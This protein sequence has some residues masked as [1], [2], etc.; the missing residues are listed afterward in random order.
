MAD[1]A[2]LAGTA[3]HC[4]VRLPGVGF[5]CR[6]G[7]RPRGRLTF[8]AGAKKVSQE[9]T[10]NTTQRAVVAVDIGRCAP[11]GGAHGLAQQALDRATCASTAVLRPTRWFTRVKRFSLPFGSCRIAPLATVSA[12]AGTA[13]AATRGGPPATECRHSGAQTCWQVPRCHLIPG[14]VER[15]LRETV[16][17]TGRSE[18]TAGYGHHRTP[19]CIQGAF[20]AYFLCTS[21]ESESAAGPKP[22]PALPAHTRQTNC[23]AHSAASK[24]SRA[25]QA[26]T[27]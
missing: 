16:R 22:P 21:K 15:L 9:S 10:L 2:L 14:P 26:T 13:S 8:F 27:S 17:T 6:R 19:R 11:A 23:E 12:V 1:A 4:V 3:V 5:E 25:R 20:L 24:A 18:A 7:F